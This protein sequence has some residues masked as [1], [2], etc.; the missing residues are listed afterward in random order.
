MNLDEKLKGRL[1]DANTEQAK[2]FFAKLATPAFLGRIGPVCDRMAA[3]IALGRGLVLS[4]DELR[5]V[6]I[7]T[8]VSSAMAHDAYLKAVVS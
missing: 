2:A 4:A 6:A 8:F 3:A 5:D 7:A 1:V